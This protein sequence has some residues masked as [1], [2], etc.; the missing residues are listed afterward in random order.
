[1]LDLS[2]LWSSDFTN[3]HS[4]ENYRVLVIPDPDFSCSNNQVSPSEDYTCSGLNPETDYTLL[5]SAINCR[6]QEGESFSFMLQ[7][8]DLGM[9]S[10][11]HKIEHVAS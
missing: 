2:L 8:Q 7:S 6:T 4:V 11:P 9:K 1:M 5:I 10:P 3:R